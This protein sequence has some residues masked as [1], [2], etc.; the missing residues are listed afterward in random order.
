MSRSIFRAF[1]YT[2]FRVFFPTQPRAFPLDFLVGS[3]LRSLCI[4]RGSSHLF[5][6]P[7]RRAFPMSSLLHFTVY[8]LWVPPPSITNRL[9][10][11]SCDIPCVHCV[12]GSVHLSCTCV[13]RAFRGR[14]LARFSSCI[15]RF[16]M[17]SLIVSRCFPAIFAVP[18]LFVTPC[19][20]YAVTDTSTSFPGL[21]PL[22]NWEG[23]Q[24][25]KALG[26]RLLVHFPAHYSTSF[27]F[28]P[29]AF[30]FVFRCVFLAL[31]CAF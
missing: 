24:K 3:L 15:F 1:R 22:G 13:P 23:R 7:L 19:V 26:T 14:F 25:G 11:F 27:L 20:S 5:S 28:I 2:L 31:P 8:L 6:R 4:R 30:P 12:N 9:C 21:F 10:R 29:L 17:N 16:P 18:Y